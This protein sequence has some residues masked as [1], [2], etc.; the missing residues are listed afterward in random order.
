M[1]VGGGSDAPTVL[2]IISPACEVSL[3]YLA[4][5]AAAAAR[6][7]AISESRAYS[8]PMRP[9]SAAAFTAGL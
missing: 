8:L 3:C 5:A 2:T 1:G 7:L 9:C 6:P 4:D